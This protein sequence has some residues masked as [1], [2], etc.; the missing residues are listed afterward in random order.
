[1]H[2]MQNPLKLE[3]TSPRPS[4]NNAAAHVRKEYS[5]QLAIWSESKDT[6]ISAIYKPVLNEPNA[7]DIVEQDM[8]EIKILLAAYSQKEAGD[9]INY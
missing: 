6:C 3:K 8:L 9:P 2:E 5:N 7:L 1:M 4:N